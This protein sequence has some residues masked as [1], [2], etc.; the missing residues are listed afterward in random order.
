MKLVLM[1]FWGVMGHSSNE[2]GMS[3]VTVLGALLV[4][5]VWEVG[6]P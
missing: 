1:V 6:L 2:I 4:L 3:E 5:W